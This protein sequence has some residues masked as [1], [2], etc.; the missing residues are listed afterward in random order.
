MSERQKRSPTILLALL[1]AFAV[2]GVAGCD[3]NAENG[4]ANSETGS[5]DAAMADDR[6]ITEDTQDS[7]DAD[8]SS[9]VLAAEREEAAIDIAGAY[10][11]AKTDFTTDQFDWKVEA[12]AQDNDGQWWA[13]VSAVPK[14]DMSLETEQI[15]VYSPA[16]SGFWFAHDMGTGID[17]ATDES[18]PEEVRDHL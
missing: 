2:M 18:F 6:A 5:T 12:A 17:P 10:F 14:D 13:R 16:D 11:V 3:G 7:P 4:A 8:S 15:Y 1:L 9:D